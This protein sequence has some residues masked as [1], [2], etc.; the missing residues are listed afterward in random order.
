MARSWRGLAR[1]LHLVQAYISL[2]VAAG[3]TRRPVLAP[4]KPGSSDGIGVRV[5]CTGYY[6]SWDRPEIVGLVGARSGWKTR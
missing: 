2:S 4:G 6:G 5:E 1:D 3:S